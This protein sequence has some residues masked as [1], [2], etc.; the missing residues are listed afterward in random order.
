VLTAG[1]ALIANRMSNMNALLVRE[2]RSVQFFPLKS[3]EYR[4]GTL[5]SRFARKIERFLCGESYPDT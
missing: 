3:S 2:N 4:F 1:F 5:N